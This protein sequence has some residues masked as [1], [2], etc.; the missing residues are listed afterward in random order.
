M[1]IDETLK[2]LNFCFAYL[3]EIIIYSK[4]EKEHLHHLWQVFD[5]LCS[6]NVNLKSTKY[7]FIKAQIHYLGHLLS[8]ERYDLCLKNLIQ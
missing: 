8:Q 3:D 7:D 1:V 6:A 5:H 4:T 2:E